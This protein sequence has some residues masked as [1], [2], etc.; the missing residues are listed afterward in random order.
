MLDKQFTFDK[1]IFNEIMKN[2]MRK[3]FVLLEMKTHYSK[4]AII[5][6]VMRQRWII[7]FECRH[8]YPSK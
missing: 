8:C 1:Y 2:K 6:T 7:F 4:A 3:G 5:K